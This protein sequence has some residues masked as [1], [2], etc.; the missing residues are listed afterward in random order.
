VKKALNDLLISRKEITTELMK[1]KTKNSETIDERLYN[2]FSA[3]RQEPL[4]KLK[5][6]AEQYLD[7]ILVKESIVKKPV[8]FTNKKTYGI[9]F[10]KKEGGVQ[11]GAKVVL[12]LKV[13]EQ[14]IVYYVKTHAYGAGNPEK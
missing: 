10:H 7:N 6:K 9:G 8:T 5:R 3:L 13:P 14:E 2:I 4:D 12:A 11:L 1:E